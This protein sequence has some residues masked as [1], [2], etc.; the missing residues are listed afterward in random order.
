M[1]YTPLNAP[2]EPET[3]LSLEFSD[4][5]LLRGTHPHVLLKDSARVFASSAPSAEELAKQLELSQPVS[6]L[7][8]FVSHSWRTERFDKY[9]ALLLYFNAV[10]AFIAMLCVAFGWSA[11]EHLGIVPWIP[12]PWQFAPGVLGEYTAVPQV[13]AIAAMF[14]TLFYWQ[15]MRRTLLEAFG[16]EPLYCFLDKVCIDQVD[17]ER[18][19]AGIRSLGAFLTSSQT[20]LVVFSKEYFTRLWCV[21]E[22]AAYYHA[23]KPSQRLVF[24]PVCFPKLL[25]P[26]GLIFLSWAIPTLASPFLALLPGQPFLPIVMDQWDYFLKAG[27]YFASVFALTQAKVYVAERRLMNDQM[28]NFSVRNA[29]CFD[30]ND[31]AKVEKNIIEWFGSEEDRDGA[32]DAF[33]RYVRTEVKDAMESFC[34]SSSAAVPYS[35][36]LLAN[37]INVMSDVGWNSPSAASDLPAAA[38]VDSMWGSFCCINTTGPVTAL[39]LLL[40]AQVERLNA[41]FGAVVF[42]AIAFAPFSPWTYVTGL[43]F[44][45][46]G[47]GLWQRVAA[48][49]AIGLMTAAVFHRDMKT[50]RVYHF[51]FGALWPAYLYF[52]IAWSPEMAQ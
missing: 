14:V 41:W 27:L 20:L 6:G 4:A 23:R 43:G 18:K 48:Q 1:S 37:W 52:Y 47:L 11:L 50:D 38:Y 17:V 16:T 25:A 10:P 31:R 28:S 51:V 19:T 39:C 40:V 44:T 35:F 5:S 22:L 15:P 12:V 7:S 13:L 2:A 29:E 33:D 46:A 42:W 30:E 49:V 3:G 8:C 45:T 32:L 26:M 24:L 21:Y 9:L 34:G 36:A